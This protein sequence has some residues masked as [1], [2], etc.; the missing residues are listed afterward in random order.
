M[1]FKKNFKYRGQR[2]YFYN[3]GVESLHKKDIKSKRREVTDGQ[4]CPHK[5]KNLYDKNN[6]KLKSRLRLKGTVFTPYL[7]D[8]GFIIRLKQK[9]L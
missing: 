2:E 6:M 9:H 7:K 1:K 4:I 5:N 3:F 8:K